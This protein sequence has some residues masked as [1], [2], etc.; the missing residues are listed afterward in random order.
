MNSLLNFLIVVINSARKKEKVRVFVTA[1]D[2]HP[3]LIFASKVG[4][5]PSGAIYCYS[6][7]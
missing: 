7:M 1:S 2:F 4:A 3:S 5:Y 6:G